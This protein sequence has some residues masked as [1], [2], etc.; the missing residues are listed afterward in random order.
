MKTLVIMRHAQAENHAPSDFERPLSPIGILQAEETQAW[1]A[2]HDIV[3]D[4]ALVSSSRRTTMTSSYI[5]AASIDY[6]DDLYGASAYELKN[7]ISLIDDSVNTVIVIAHNPGVSDFVH[8]AGVAA[9][10]RTAE[11]VAFELDGSWAGI[12]LRNLTFTARYQRP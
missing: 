11:C 8:Q 4:L 7:A 6:Q 10:L 5:N 9:N 1:L 3:L 2:R 12:D